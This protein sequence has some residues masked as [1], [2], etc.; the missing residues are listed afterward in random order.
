VPLAQALYALR[1]IRPLRRNVS[2]KTSDYDD[3]LREDILVLNVIITK[4]DKALLA[5]FVIINDV[6]GLQLHINN[7]FKD[8][9]NVQIHQ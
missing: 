1:Y 2:C 6:F 3:V 5:L 7:V 8:I 4:Y 9:N